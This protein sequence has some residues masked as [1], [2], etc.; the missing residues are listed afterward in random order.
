MELPIG[1]K[2]GPVHL[3][4]GFEGTG[5]GA[6]DVAGKGFAERPHLFTYVGDTWNNFYCFCQV[7]EVYPLSYHPL[8]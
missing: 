7:R 8:A 3:F 1:H 5:L 6:M 4:D 2:I